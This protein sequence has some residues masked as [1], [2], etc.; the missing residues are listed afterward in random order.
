MRESNALGSVL[1]TRPPP[2]LT[3]HQEY[4]TCCSKACP[5]SAPF[6]H[7]ASLAPTHPHPIKGVRWVALRKPPMS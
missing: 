4:E 6:V 7:I 3:E 5:A 2:S 1:Y